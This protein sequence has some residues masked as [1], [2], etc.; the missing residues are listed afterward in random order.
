MSERDRFEPGPPGE[1]TATGQPAFSS[2]AEAH[3]SRRSRFSFLRRAGPFLTAA[4]LALTFATFPIPPGDLVIDSDSSLAAVL[5]FARA[6]GLQFGHDLFI[7][8]GPLG[9]LVFF[10]SSLESAGLRMCADVGLAFTVMLGICLVAWRLP[11]VWRCLLLVLFCFQ[12]PNIVLKTDPVLDCGLLC[13]GLLCFIETGR[14][15]VWVT[16]AFTALTVFAGLAKVSYLF[17]AA[18]GLLL[19]AGDLAARGRFRLSVGVL[20]GYPAALLGG[21]L[22]A[23]QHLAHFL[24]FLKNSFLMVQAYNQALG[25][26]GLQVVKLSG[27]ALVFLSAGTI[28]ARVAFAYGPEEK[29]RALRR[30][31][32]LGWT[33]LLLFIVWK[34]GFVREDFAHT[35][36]FLVFVPVLA[37]ALEIVPCDSRVS[38]RVAQG[39]ALV[40]GCL[41]LAVSQYLYFPTPSLALRQPLKAFAENVRSLASPVKYL[42]WHGDAWETNRLAAALPKFRQIIGPASTGCFGH[43]P[44]YVL[45]NDLNY[46]P[47]PLF[48]SYAAADGSLMRLNVQF[49]LSNPPKFVIFSLGGVDRK[50]SVLEDALVLRYLLCN[51]ELVA[52][53]AQFL[54]LKEK[55][56]EPPRLTLLREGD[57]T[58]SERIDLTPWSETNLWL[59][60]DL[61]PSLTGRLRE[62]LYRAPTV[63]LAA[64]R[65]PD[66]LARRRAPAAGMS[67]GFLASPLL[68]ETS[69]VQKLHDGEL[70]RPTAYSVKITPGEEGFW[71]KRIRYR[72]YRIESPLRP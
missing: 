13:W 14:R 44:V 54:L 22:A 24:E 11:L 48:L 5:G 43:Y 66:L 28:I 37:L 46:K 72:L 34:H 8:Y 50:F 53:E 58:L 63:R 47:A 36:C 23:G 18:L 39:F 25:W 57:V 41:S 3:D 56:R 4:F 32:L 12:V 64:W 29:R 27:L 35:P 1:G 19:L 16:V 70:K 10:Y 71:Q 33:L 55:T 61:R 26:D 49:Y 67:A 68:L 21:W 69:E 65:G 30:L 6:H 45:L 15:L 2:A 62:F 60:L 59:E 42:H 40:G 20:I 9:H 7:T 52:A 17:G 38:L 31:F 51:Y